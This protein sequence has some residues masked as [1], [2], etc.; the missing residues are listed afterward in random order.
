M[1]EQAYRELEMRA[2]NKCGKPLEAS[3]HHR[4]PARELPQFI[5]EARRMFTPGQTFG[6]LFFAVLVRV[7]CYVVSHS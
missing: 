1:V 5:S 4:D 6:R 3:L 7:A 2:C